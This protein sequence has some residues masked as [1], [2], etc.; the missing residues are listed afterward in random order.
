MYN[1]YTVQQK[2][3]RGAVYSTL[4]FVRVFKV[5]LAIICTIPVVLIY[6]SVDYKHN[7]SMLDICYLG[8]QCEE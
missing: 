4:L 6:D 1:R 8:I 5:M 2:H 7:V 3:A